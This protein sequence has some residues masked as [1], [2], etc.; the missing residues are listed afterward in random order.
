MIQ[1][2]FSISNKTFPYVLI[3]FFLNNIHISVKIKRNI[4]YLDYISKYCYKEL[5][6][7]KE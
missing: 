6:N 4:A 1:I 2:F 7:I 3:Y 5:K